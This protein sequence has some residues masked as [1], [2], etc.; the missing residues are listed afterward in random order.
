MAPAHGP[1]SIDCA[2]YA[3]V[4]C[5]NAGYAPVLYPIWTV[6][7]PGGS[8]YVW[9]A[10]VPGYRAPECLHEYDR[11]CAC[12]CDRSCCV[13]ASA[14]ADSPG[15][16]GPTVYA[17]YFLRCQ[18]GPHCAVL[19]DHTVLRQTAEKTAAVRQGDPA[20]SADVVSDRRRAAALDHHLSV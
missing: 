2:L 1:E 8:L 12:H 14:Y 18:S 15:I 3:A 19:F 4:A 20:L 9:T 6:R 10:Y 17:V 16:L 13:R 11:I 5:R 7:D